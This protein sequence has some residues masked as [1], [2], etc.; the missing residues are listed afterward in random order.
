MKNKGLNLEKI[1]NITLSIFVSCILG[2][3]F[4]GDI[5]YGL[6]LL[7]VAFLFYKHRSKKCQ[8]KK[9]E[10][11]QKEFKDYLVSVSDAT[12]T[13]YSVENA[14]KEAYKDYSQMY[15]DKG[16][17]KKHIQIMISQINLNIP[18]E[19]VI[20]EF[21][22]RTEIE[23]AFTFSQIFEVAKHR[24]GSLPAVIRNVTE[25]I[26]LKEN[27]KED[28]K[29]AIAEKHMEQKVMTFI[30]IALI[31]YIS[32]SSPGFLDVMYETMMGRIVMTI[33][34]M[35]YIAAYMWSEKL[36]QIEV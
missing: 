25:T 31:A 9:Y 18:I 10:L 34:L 15:G 3:I 35:A 28:I 12:E 20:K 2:E 23:A 7:P 1:G 14:I 6:L 30:P 17:L 21:A 26:V 22:Q 24:G 36:T 13:G 16:L 5:L 33:C 19:K 11:M 4:Y 27:I 29:V 8:K 32:F